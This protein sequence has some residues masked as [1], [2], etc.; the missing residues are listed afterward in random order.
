MTEPKQ[1]KDRRINF[2]IYYINDM[3]LWGYEIID[4]IERVTLKRGYNYPDMQAA[5]A[6]GFEEA[7]KVIHELEEAQSESD[8]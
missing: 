7:K 6:A 5:R 3:Y 8:V 2:G 4:Q 1:N